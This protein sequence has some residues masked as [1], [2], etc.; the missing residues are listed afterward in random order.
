MNTNDSE[1][2]LDRNN[3]IQTLYIDTGGDLTK[4][5]AV[6][7][8]WRY[9]FIYLI[10]LLGLLVIVLL[11]LI[12]TKNNFEGALYVFDAKVICLEQMTD[13]DKCTKR[14]SST[15]LGNEGGSNANDCNVYNNY[16]KTCFDEV[17]KYNQRCSIYITEYR[18]CLNTN[19]ITN[20][21]DIKALCGTEVSDI[22]DC[23]INPDLKV[24][25][26]LYVDKPTN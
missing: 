6:S 8:E 11:N 17:V 24:D 2:N 25:P 10:V 12:A 19:K 20:Y 26:L 23:N 21:K 5:R 7:R 18:E 9:C 4:P 14:S 16:V 15:L 1:S 3:I 22:N 13:Y